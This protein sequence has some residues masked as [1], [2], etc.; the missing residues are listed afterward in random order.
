MVPKRVDIAGVKT[1]HCHQVFVGVWWQY[2]LSASHAV[3]NI[4]KAEKAFL[5]LGNIGTFHRNLSGHSIFETCITY[6]SME[7][8]FKFGCNNRQVA[9]KIPMWNWL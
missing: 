1:H 3:Q 7:L 8:G 6:T 2:N 9:G 4:G 5:A